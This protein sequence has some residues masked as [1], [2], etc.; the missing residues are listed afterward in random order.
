MP[1]CLLIYHELQ[2]RWEVDPAKF[3]PG[4]D[5]AAGPRATPAGNADCLEGSYVP[6]SSG[7]RNCLGLVRAR[8]CRAVQRPSLMETTRT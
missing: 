1:A 4:E 5:P 8:I 7:S 3:S 6:F 2:E